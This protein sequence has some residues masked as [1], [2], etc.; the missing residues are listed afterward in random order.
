MNNETNVFVL[1]LVFGLAVGVIFIGV[2]ALGRITTL[3]A[4]VEKQQQI[5]YQT[6]NVPITK[7]GKDE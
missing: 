4:Q 5:I 2:P 7:G 6:Y 3:N 1:G